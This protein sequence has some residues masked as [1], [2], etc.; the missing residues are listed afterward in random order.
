MKLSR[1]YFSRDIEKEEIEIKFNLLNLDPFRFI[2]QTDKWFKD[3]E[4]KPFFRQF[5]L[6]KQKTGIQEWKN[7]VSFYGQK[8][9][10][11]LQQILMLGHSAFNKKL[12]FPVVKIFKL[13]RVKSESVLT[14]Y[15]NKSFSRWMTLSE[16]DELRKRLERKLNIK[17]SLLGTMQRE[18]IWFYVGNSETYRNFSINAD[19]CISEKRP[20]LSQLEIEYKG[21]AGIYLSEGKMAVIEETVNLGR[22]LSKKS[23]MLQPTNLT[24]AQ[25]ITNWT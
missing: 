1:K 24:K 8:S 7:K 20:I 3:G 19:R 14:R 21:R 18:K 17:I 9:K 13:S 4:L 15:E 10:N 22:L 6:G 23:N 2:F 25:W 16:F 11:D 12:Y 5:C